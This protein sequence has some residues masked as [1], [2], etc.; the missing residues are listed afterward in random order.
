MS[1]GQGAERVFIYFSVREPG[2]E[3]VRVGQ[4]GVSV[5]I[6]VGG[7]IG[8]GFGV[9]GRQESGRQGVTLLGLS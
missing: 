3:V 4:G 6:R 9:K 8:R 5:S 1:G 2:E 7:I